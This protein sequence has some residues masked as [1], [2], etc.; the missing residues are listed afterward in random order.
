MPEKGFVLRLP[1]P[2]N[3]LFKDYNRWLFVYFLTTVSES[4]VS[5]LVLPV[6]LVGLGR[7]GFVAVERE[8][9]VVAVAFMGGETRKGKNNNDGVTTGKRT[10]S[11]LHGVPQHHH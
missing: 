8:T 7:V 10:D 9:V 4:R 2:K 5:V 1:F 3:L 6:L 11:V